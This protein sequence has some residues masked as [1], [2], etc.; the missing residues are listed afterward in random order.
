MSLTFTS[1]FIL[2]PS[3]LSIN[4]ELPVALEFVGGTI[5]IN[6]LGMDILV[7]TYGRRN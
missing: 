2:I 3:L 4:V 7:M 5:V 1:Y 6:K